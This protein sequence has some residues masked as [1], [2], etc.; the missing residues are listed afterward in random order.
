[1][2]TLEQILWVTGVILLGIFCTHLVASESARSKD[3][4]AF[5]AS[6]E[7]PKW[8]IMQK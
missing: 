8:D 2:K 7:R 6:W 3:I 4:D 1:M 5:K